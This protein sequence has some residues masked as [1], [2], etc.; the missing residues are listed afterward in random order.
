MQAAPAIH[1]TL[2]PLREKMQQT[3]QQR[4][5]HPHTRAGVRGLL[6]IASAD[7]K[8]STLYSRSNSHH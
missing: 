7:F 6:L 5:P 4:L 1:C 3:V 2:A 8:P